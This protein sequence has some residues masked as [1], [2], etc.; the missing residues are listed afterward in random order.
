MF[1]L[2]HYYPR[3][4]LH[5][6]VEELGLPEMPLVPISHDPDVPPLPPT[7]EE[8]DPTMICA[9]HETQTL[10]VLPQMKM[11]QSPYLSIL[12]HLSSVAP[13]AGGALFGPKG[14][15]VVT[16]YVPDRLGKATAIS[17]TLHAPSLNA[18]LKQ[19]L[20]VDMNCKGLVHSHPAGMACPSSGDLAY[21]RR[22]LSSKKNQAATEFLLPI[23]CDGQFHPFLILASDP[24]RI[25]PAQLLLF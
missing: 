20:A 24:N 21:V 18:I 5:D 25:V 1:P 19:F 22:C 23:F 10:T 16:H 2:R 17:F 4:L 3:G 14:E 11:L 6:H 13:E 9:G 12:Q 15:N 7:D 8:P